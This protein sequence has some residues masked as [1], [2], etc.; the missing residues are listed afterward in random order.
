MR[1]SGRL[2][3][4]P[5]GWRGRHGVRPGLCGRHPPVPFAGGHC[6]SITWSF[7]PNSTVFIFRWHARRQSRNT[8]LG[9]WLCASVR[10]PSPTLPPR[11][12][13]PRMPRFPVQRTADTEPRSGASR[14]GPH[15][16]LSPALNRF[17]FAVRSRFLKGRKESLARNI[18]NVPI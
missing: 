12:P 5:W 16:V 10:R 9:Y 2:T 1:Q 8:K 3:S 4:E 18:P 13:T 11:P 7:R 6:F 14:T 17:A 15:S